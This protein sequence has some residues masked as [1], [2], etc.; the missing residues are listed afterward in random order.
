[1]VSNKALEVSYTIA[2]TIVKTKQ[3]HTI[4]ESLVLSSCLE[5]VK[6]MKNE[7]AVKKVKIVP[8][9]DNSIRRRIDDMSDEILLQLK[10][11]L[12]KSEV[13]ALQLDES[14]DI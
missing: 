13:F 2:K 5:I 6:I 1:M 14:T 8:L 10:D 3:P 9:S 4:A 7:N 11:S 12:M